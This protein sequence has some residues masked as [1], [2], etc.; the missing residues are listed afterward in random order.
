MHYEN[1]HILDVAH[2]GKS[3]NIDWKSLISHKP[4]YH[5]VNKCNIADDDAG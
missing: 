3:A 4:V 1:V 5:G 2:D